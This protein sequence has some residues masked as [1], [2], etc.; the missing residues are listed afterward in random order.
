M[1]KS[2]WALAA[3]YVDS[4]L[5]CGRESRR[6]IGADAKFEAA[7]PARKVCSSR[8]VSVKKLLDWPMAH[9]VQFS[10]VHVT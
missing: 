5:F 8:I 6:F 9:A 4:R 2:R 3:G 7:P 1:Q 10:P